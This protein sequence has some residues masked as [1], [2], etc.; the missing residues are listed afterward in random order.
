MNPSGIQNKYGYSTYMGY[1]KALAYTHHL[2]RKISLYFAERTQYHRKQAEVC[3]LRLT[4]VSR[5]CMVV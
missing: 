1:S 5:D 3:Y 4:V 2:D